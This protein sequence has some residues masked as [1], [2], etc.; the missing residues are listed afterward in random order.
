M[1]K[2]IL[3]IE[4]DEEI[5]EELSEILRGEGYAAEISSDG[6]NALA[7]IEK[8]AYDLIILDLKIPGINGI[9]LLKVIKEKKLKLKVLV[10]TARPL[11]H[12]GGIQKQGLAA[13]DAKEQR[14]LRRCHGIVRKPFD[15]A[16]L[17]AKIRQLL[18]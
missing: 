6:L 13:L 12:E 7:L 9:E 5:C 10:V 1:K 4:D 17:L 18:K 3:I 15:V 14:L 2:K 11:K 16:S 8:K